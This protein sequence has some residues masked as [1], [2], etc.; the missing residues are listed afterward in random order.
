MRHLSDRVSVMYLGRI[1]ERADAD[2]VFDAARHPY[3][4]ALLAAVPD[5]GGAV[6]PQLIRGDP[7]S[8]ADPPAGCVFHP[9]CWLRERLPAAD[10]ARC[11]AE[12][13]PVVT[14][15]VRASCHFPDRVAGAL[16]G[17]D[18]PAR[19]PG[20]AAGSGE[21]V[22]L[23]NWQDP[24]QLRWAYLHIPDLIPTA[25]VSRGDGP[26]TPLPRDTRDLDGLAL[27]RPR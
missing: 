17:D 9:R 22:T 13:P 24:P 26:V 2:E 14:G 12:V 3:S 5:I 18:S 15:D 7:P 20:P 6:T 27:H 23:A 10:A 25:V 16:P 1:M 19:I 8:P 4:R 11:A 21:G